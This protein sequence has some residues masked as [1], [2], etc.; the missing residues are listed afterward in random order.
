MND[1]DESQAV[2]ERY[3]RRAVHD[4]RYSLFDPAALR[5]RQGRQRALLQMLSSHGLTDLSALRLVEVGCGD[6][7]NLL[8]LLQL[9]FAP[10]H[11]QGI[12]TVLISTDGV[13][14]LLPFEALPGKAEGTL[15]IEVYRLAF[16]PV[17]QLIPSLLA[18]R[19]DAA[20]ERQ[21]DRKSVV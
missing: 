15:L 5:E 18:L 21:V 13:L 9:G 16:V 2:R 19:G 3:A 10:E 6:G 17:P 8:E 11:L 12:E 1:Q 14:G 7:H 20:T 4:A